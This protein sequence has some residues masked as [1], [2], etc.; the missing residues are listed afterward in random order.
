MPS[1]LDYLLLINIPS[2]MSIADR[3]K[4]KRVLLTGT[5][6]FVGKVM[7][8]KFLYSVSGVDKI[9]VLIRAKDGSNL[10]ERFKKEI[11][12]SPCFNRLRSIHKGKFDEF[13]Q[14]KVQPMYA[15]HHVDKATFSSR[16]SVYP[17]KSGN[18]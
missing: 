14:H 6:G 12:S 9:Y 5:T 7:L 8:E 10:Y 11:V 3:F 2:I 18:S 16:S 4:G 15:H 17:L 1:F 13:I